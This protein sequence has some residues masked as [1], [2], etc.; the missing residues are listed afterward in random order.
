MA[1]E[2]K[3]IIFYRCNLFIFHFVSR[4]ERPAMASQPNL[5]NRLE[6]VSIYKCPQKIRGPSPKFG[7]QKHQL[8]DHFFATSALD[9][10]YVRNE[11]SH[12]QTKMLV[13]IY[14]VPPKS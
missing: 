9:T 11:A 13:S 4:D 10:A 8:F 5:G 1:P 7:A 6:V 12:R 2:G 3:A 14:N